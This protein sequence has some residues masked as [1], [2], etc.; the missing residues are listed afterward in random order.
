MKKIVLITGGKGLLGSTLIK[1]APKFVDIIK[2]DLDV[3]NKSQIRKFSQTHKKIDLV[4]HAAAIT[5]VGLCEKNHT[6]AFNVNVDGTRNILGLCR[7]LNCGL[8]YISTFSVFNGEKGG[9]KE[10]DE[11]FPIRYYDLTKYLGE[12]IVLNYEK[13][14]VIRTGLIGIHEKSSK[15][16]NF[17]DWLIDSIKRNKNITL[18]NDVLVNPLSNWTLADFIFEFIKLWPQRKTGKN[19]RIVH[20]GTHDVVSK[21][22]IGKLILKKMGQGLPPKQGYKGKVKYCSIDRVEGEVKQKLMFLNVEFAE[23]I[24]GKKMPTI[25]SEVN[26]IFNTM[27]NAQ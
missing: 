8:I 6:F 25:T 27:K 20:V 7:K 23:K 3:T 21:A 24:F 22:D 14:F 19:L 9:Y 11:P 18:F 5:D 26:K 1:S 2:D 4:I 15:H 13:C 17:L 12:L 16:H 10:N